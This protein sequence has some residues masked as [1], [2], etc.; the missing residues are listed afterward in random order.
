LPFP[1][2]IK[3]SDA[4]QKLAAADL[5]LVPANVTLS[6]RTLFEKRNRTK[7]LGGGT[8]FT[9][10]T[11][12]N[13]AGNAQID[14]Q[15]FSSMRASLGWDTTRDL[16]FPETV[17]SRETLG[18]EAL[19]RQSFDFDWTI[20]IASWLTPRYNYRTTSNRNHTREA[21]R[22]LDSLDLRDFGAT[23]SKTLTVQFRVVELVQAFRSSG[24]GGVGAGSPRAGWWARFLGPI[25]FDRRQRE[26]VLYVQEEDDP[27]FGFG[28]GFGSLDDES[29]EEPQSFTENDDW[30]LST[31]LQPVRT[32]R[33]R[34]AYR[35]TDNVRRYLQ[36]VNQKSIRTWPDINV[37]WTNAWLPGAVRKAI[38]AATVSSGFQRRTSS[39]VS[40]DQL[41][42]DLDRRLWDP[43]VAVRL[44]WVNGM[45]TDFRASH[46]ETITAAI[47]GGSVDNR[48]EELATDFTIN[49]NYNIRP[50]TTLYI[51]FPTLWKAKLRQPLLT[52][53]S[54]ARRSREDSTALRDDRKRD[55]RNTTVGME[56]FLDF[57]F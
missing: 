22:S 18:V 51:P 54:F 42:G 1:T 20:P 3:G 19:R 7:V 32:L 28:W 6:T 2:A 50:G 24:D 46:S 16:V 39:D 26:S 25:R 52:S 53:V 31:T 36:G 37:N 35:E 23:R 11:T 8:D 49:F 55:I 10:D 41:L 45:S 47:R 14:F 4:L 21:S 13:V 48:R 17:I 33:I 30:G 27:S 57:L 56:A 9:A 40:N 44:T 12:R 29:P 34:G 5:N 15:L 43:V 38:V